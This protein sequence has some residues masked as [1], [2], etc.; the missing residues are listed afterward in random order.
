MH[1][2]IHPFVHLFICCFF[3]VS[4]KSGAIDNESNYFGGPGL[5]WMGTVASLVGRCAFPLTGPLCVALA[6]KP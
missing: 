6:H 4:I 5:N 2:S 3:F 1:G